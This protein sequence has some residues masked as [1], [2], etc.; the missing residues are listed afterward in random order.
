MNEPIDIPLDLLVLDEEYQPRI[1]GVS[2]QHIRQLMQS[3]PSTWPPL[4]VTPSGRG[5]GSYLVIDGW[6]RVLAA[7]SMAP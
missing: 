2:Q 6:H 7:R 1:N 3:D 5:D 4:L